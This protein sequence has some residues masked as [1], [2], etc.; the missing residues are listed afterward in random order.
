M[1]VTGYEIGV[2]PCNL[3]MKEK[4]RFSGKKLLL[5]YLVIS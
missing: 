1:A 5:V 2:K 4:A 3:R